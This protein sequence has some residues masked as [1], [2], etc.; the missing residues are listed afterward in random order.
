MALNL[1]RVFLHSQKAAM[2]QMSTEAP[3]VTIARN[4]LFMQRV[5]EAKDEA[6]L[7]KIALPNV[8]LANLPTELSS[9][10]GYLSLT[11]AAASTEKFT[12]DPTAW[13]NMDFAAFAAT[14][15]QRTETWPFLLGFV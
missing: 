4:I 1:R 11:A 9:M 12:A 6:A 10:S 5:A 8:D 7:Q 15:A 3:K 13:Q 14:E 2:R